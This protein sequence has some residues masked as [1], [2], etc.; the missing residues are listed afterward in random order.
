MVDK[1]VEEPVA[2]V[3]E[4]KSIIKQSRGQTETVDENNSVPLDEQREQ[5]VIK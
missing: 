2:E 1:K 5:I 3:I 4:V